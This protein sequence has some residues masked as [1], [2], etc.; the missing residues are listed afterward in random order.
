ELKTRT[1]AAADAGETGA[2]AEAGQTATAESRQASELGTSSKEAGWRPF[3]CLY[4]TREGPHPSAEV[5][6]L[7]DS[8]FF[9]THSL[10]KAGGCEICI[11]SNRE[12]S[13]ASPGGNRVQLPKSNTFGGKIGR[14][15]CR[16]RV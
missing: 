9:L 16:E 14:A 15:S 13:V 10:R 11:A 8:L 3:R 12:N 4:N 2:A 1:A 6:I 5:A 7:S